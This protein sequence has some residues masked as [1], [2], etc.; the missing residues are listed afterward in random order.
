[1][2]W[3]E[4]IQEINEVTSKTHDALRKSNALDELGVKPKKK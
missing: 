1:M 4:K 2:F 3:Q